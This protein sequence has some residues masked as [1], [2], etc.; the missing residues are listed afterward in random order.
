[1]VRDGERREWA[2]EARAYG[3]NNGE[4]KRKRM[5]S[6]GGR[7]ERKLAWHGG[8][9]ERKGGLKFMKKPTT[10]SIFLTLISALFGKNHIKTAPCKTL[11]TPIF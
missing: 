1:M 7:I 4:N 11:G 9:S 8:I 10:I 2:M 6:S 5:G 3:L